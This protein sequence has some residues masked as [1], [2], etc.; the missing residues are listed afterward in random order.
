M[1]TRQTLA[2]F[3]ATVLISLAAL[4]CAQEVVETP[5]QPVESTETTVARTDGPTGTGGMVA[6]AHRR[7]TE[8][9]L[10]I[11]ELGGNAFDA[12]V[13]VAATLTVVEPMNSSIFGGY[14]TVIVYDAERGEL[15]YLD[16]NGRFPKAT[17]S[18]VF[19]DAPN[20]QDMMWTA[21]AVSTPGNLRGFEALWMEH[22][23][24]PWVDLW[25]AAIFH[26]DEGIGVTAP[27][28]RAIAGAWDHFSARAKEIY[29]AGGEPFREGDWLGQHELAASM[30]TVAAEGAA[31]LYGGSV[32]EAV[33]AEVDRRDGFLAMED[34][35]EH[36]AEW[37]EPISIDYHGYQ[38]VTAGAPSNSFAALVAA[39]IMSRYDT[40]ALGSN[41]TAYLHRFAEATKHAFWAR[42]KYAGGPEVDPP[43]LDM[44]LSE[45][46]WQEQVDALDAGH[47]GSFTPPGPTSTEGADT[48]HFVV[49]DRW[50]NVVSATVTLGQGFGSAV[51]VA[52][53][54]IWLNNS[55]A[56]S[57][58][59]P[60]GN[61]MDATAGN[62]KHSSKS[63]TIIM[64]DGRPWAAIGSP[65]GHTIPQTVAQLTINLIDFEMDVQT[66]VDTPR[67]AF[68]E[69][70]LLLVDERVPEQVRAELEALGHNVRPTGGVGLPHALRIEYDADGRPTRFV[71]AA[72]SRGVGTAVGLDAAIVQ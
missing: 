59:E 21:K 5:T 68:A 26:A 47:A 34:L 14:G 16:N 42:L 8:A 31:A 29:G 49:A 44:L 58:Y 62:R 67:V 4:G 1:K 24:L 65:G 52:D 11:L 2:L 25:E 71:G 6:S 35:V 45:A 60:K 46:Y 13:A 72:D 7:A 39:G 40:R 9:G 48:T 57:T 69:P 61:P 56:F 55:M 27:L 18:D 53:A 32:G 15:R 66:A 3:S 41:T 17:N 20:L 30:R 51:L 43:P 28:G 19:R 12:A 33:I 54:G 50:G 70:D 36:E 22:G 37:F 10:E 38:V 63:P 23:S 64:K